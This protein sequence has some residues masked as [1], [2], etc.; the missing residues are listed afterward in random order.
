MQ[1]R[2]DTCLSHERVQF[3]HQLRRVEDEV[4]PGLVPA[5][6]GRAA[7]PKAIDD[8]L[9]EPRDD[10]A[11]VRGVV[12]RVPEID[13]SRG[14]HAAEEAVVLHDAH[15]RAKL[16]GAQRGKHAGATAA[17]DADVASRSNGH[18]PRRFADSRRNAFTSH[19]DLDLTEQ[20]T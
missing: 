11:L 15:V 12:E 8:L 13:Q 14:G 7:R 17:D 9:R 3:N 2:P 10:L 1:E 5:L 6:H 19:A 20:F 16:R 18:V 4:R